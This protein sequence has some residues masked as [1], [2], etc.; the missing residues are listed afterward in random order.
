MSR[1]V[2]VLPKYARKGASSR[3]RTFQYLPLLEDSGWQFTVKPLF[4]EAY[5]DSLYSGKGRSRV[6]LIC[7]YL[8]RFLLILNVFHYRFMWFEKELF[9]YMPAWIEVLLSRLRVGYVVDYDDAIFHNYDLSANKWIRRFL[10]KKIDT[11]MRHASYVIV[12]N[13]YLAERAISAGAKRVV[14][15]P[16]V[17]D[18]HRYST[19]KQPRQSITIGWIGSPT[20]QRYVENLLPVLQD[21]ARESDF[22][23]LL[24]GATTDVSDR[25]PGINVDIQPWSEDTEADLIQTMDIGIM[26]LE[27]GPWEK[28]KCGYKL[29]QYMASGV[30]VVA[31]PVGV[32]SSIVDGAGCGLLASGLDD[33]EMAFNKLVYDKSLRHKL[34]SAGRTAVKAQYSLE[35]QLAALRS[36]FKSMESNVD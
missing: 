3:L 27:D 21:L 20:T 8:R 4:N 10:G 32:N 12:G 14:I 13:N 31:S 24:V 33:W 30:P 22:R 23:L 5:L 28:G 18:H 15:I 17:V 2:L 9:P 29:I 19:A 26:P 1:P 7:A 36:C 6:A 25:F 34:G 11:V 16:T 35:S